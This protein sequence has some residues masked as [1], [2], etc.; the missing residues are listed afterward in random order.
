MM[1][2][3]TAVEIVLSPLDE[4]GYSNNRTDP[5]GETM[6]G[7]TKRVAIAHGY[8]GDMRIMPK[9]TAM[10]IY[11]AAYWDINHTDDLPEVLRFPLFDGSINSGPHQSVMWLQRALDLGDS[12]MVTALEIEV[13]AKLA[14]AFP[15]ACDL[16]ALR[17]DFLT[18]L[19]T[20]GGYGRGWS[21]RIALVLSTIA[22]LRSE[23]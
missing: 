11:R 10:A 7:V 13:A 21:R 1:D 9:A 14:D 3:D 18:N 12:G 15:V 19:P 8:L 17:L 16:V 22:A 2:F 5:G 20:W 23:P 6:W 4:G